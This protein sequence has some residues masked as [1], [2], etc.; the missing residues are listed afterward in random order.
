MSDSRRN[1]PSTATQRA[2]SYWLFSGHPDSG[3]CWEKHCDKH[4]A[5]VGLK[6]VPDWR[7]VFWNKK[8]KLLLAVYVD[9]FKMAGPSGNMAEGWKL[10]RQEIKMDAATPTGKY[11]GCSHK[12]GLVHVSAGGNPLLPDNE[13]DI[14]V[15]V[16]EYDMEQFLKQCV[17]RY[18]EP[19]AS[20]ERTCKRFRPCSLTRRCRPQRMRPRLAC[21]PRSRARS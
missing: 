9:D 10:I 14:P 13:G 4:L 1:G 21:S 16:M 15:R 17:E 12:E 8:L 3:G 20:S 18:Q 11:L 2:C 19:G 5:T 7:S 6:P